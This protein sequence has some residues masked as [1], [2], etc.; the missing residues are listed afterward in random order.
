MVTLFFRR[1]LAVAV[2][3]AD[4]V[5]RVLMSKLHKALVLLLIAVV[6]LVMLVLDL[7]LPSGVIRGIPYVVL[8]SISFWLPW[9]YAPMMLAAVGTVLIVVGYL[10]SAT[11][12]NTTALLL[13]ISLEAAVLWVTAFLVLRYRASSRSLEDREQRLRALVSTVV[14]GVMIIDANGT[15]Q[16][17]NPACE[18]LFGYR[19]DE[20]VGRNVKMLMPSP[21]QEEHDEYLSRYRN[22]GHK[23]IIGI[24]REVEG[25]RK[26]GTTFPMEL[27]VGEA[28]PGGQQVF[29]GIIRDITTRKSAEQSLRVAKE[30]AES[31]SH[32]KSQF[33][34]NMSHEIRTPMNAVLGYTQLIETDPDMPD[35]YRRPLK[36]IHSAGNHLISL[37][38]DILDLSKIEAGA[39]ELDLRD[40]D[41]G[42]LM[43]DVSGIFA[44]R[45][46]QK[47][48]KWRAD[49][50]IGERAV[51]ADDRK[52]RQILINLLG[53]AVK[54]TDRG[55]ISLKVE[56]SG[57]R[58]T[59]SVED[60]GPGITEEAQKRIF[61]P[62]QQAEEG[63]AKGG[64]GL[65]LAIT[66]RH[67]ELMGGSLSLE[68]NPGEGS[69]FRF[70]L[71]LPPAEADLILKSEQQ[72]RFCRLAEPY[73]V[74]A[75]VVDDVEDN[76][77]VLSGLL[78]RAGIEVTMASSGAEAL[79][80]IAR[81]KPDIIFMDV[82]M[83]VMD[84]LTAVRQLRE[85]WPA[86]GMVCVAITASGLLRQQSF[87]RDAGFDDFIGKPFLFEK[88]CDCMVRHL[89]VE[90]VHDPD[91][92]VPA[93][94]GPCAG[95]PD[96]IQLPEGLRE[97]L[98]A[99]ATI[100]ALTE[101]EMLIG[102]LKELNPDA[103]F[104]A[105]ELEKLLSR[106]DTDA[107]IALIERFPAGGGSGLYVKS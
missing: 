44:M 8:I 85:R 53:N 92:E 82:R 76:R 81:Q 71:E 6:L 29:V 40:F 19:E 64:T 32:A 46:E 20:V 91:T 78:D 70:E 4:P 24:G 83:P 51:R 39:M 95:E 72:G 10:F 18:K 99:A 13:N 96:K 1:T 59:F 56:Q 75:L 26:D 55:V 33:L 101:I 97:R 7:N 98:L 93:G 102:E 107:I 11:H 94:T 63:E 68:S 57:R 104:L 31:A 49:V 105:V 79:Q 106:Y 42:D 66:R 103:K 28:R 86:E 73:R 77:E 30:Q 35:K 22:T 61:E 87:Y 60:T 58:Y 23:R 54:F 88:V 15:V 34:A 25:R 2:Q 41:L 48:L 37:I 90:F 3:M 36:A 74:R 65:G 27:S 14:D 52:L 67:I 62:F 89:H 47:G 50:H 5:Q 12:F 9:R 69:S 100:N 16:E 17:Y 21:Y 84:G 45:C 80:L 43:E 38:D